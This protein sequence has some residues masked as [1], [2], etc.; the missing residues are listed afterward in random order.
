MQESVSRRKALVQMAAVAAAVVVWPRLGVAQSRKTP[1]VVYKDPNC[2]CCHKW[3]E[4]LEASGFAPSVTDTSKM[5][6]I[7]TRYK[8]AADLQSC[9][10]SMVGGYVIEGHVPAADIRKLLTEK[11]KG[12]LGLTIPG[13]PASAP[14]MDMVPFQPYTVLTFDQAGKTAVYVQHNKA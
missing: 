14:G 4:H 9:H 8:V 10:T 6:E 1:I 2:G 11:P 12:I 3:V 7:K 5:A 13:M